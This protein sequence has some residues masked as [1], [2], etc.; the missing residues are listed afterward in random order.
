MIKSCAKNTVQTDLL[1]IGI[2]YVPILINQW[3][4]LL[5]P[6]YTLAAANRLGPPTAQLNHA[7]TYKINQQKGFVRY[8]EKYERTFV[9]DHRITS[10]SGNTK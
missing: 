10:Y 6:A 3:E 2:H 1:L 5:R 9:M 7:A 8:K 4:R